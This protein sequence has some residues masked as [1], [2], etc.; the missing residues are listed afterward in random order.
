LP[1][2]FELASDLFERG[3]EGSLSESKRK[4]GAPA[5]AESALLEF[6]WDRAE[7]LF[8]LGGLAYDEIDAARGAAGRAA[9]LDFRGALA[10]AR[11]IRAARNDASFLAVVLAAK[12]IANITKEQPAHELDAAA[13]A[14]PAE[15]ALNEAREAFSVAVE[16]SLA[17]RDFAA[18][19]AAVGQLA[20]SLEVFFNEVLVMDP[21]PA[22]RSNRL[23]LLQRIGAE[24]GQLADLSRLVVD[25]AELRAST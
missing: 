5:A 16:S 20:P 14:L 25:K 24:I 15:R 11:A 9:A 17:R 18:G 1:A 12:R 3:D 22:K 2:A 13:L 4:P 23:A 8:G 6:L 21:D 19:L 10:C 7:H